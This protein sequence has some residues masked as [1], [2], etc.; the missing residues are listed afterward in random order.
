MVAIS[1]LGASV[2]FPRDTI[3]SDSLSRLDVPLS[4]RRV[5]IR[6]S[7]TLVLPL[8]SPTRSHGTDTV[9]YDMMD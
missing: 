9:L 8:E 4:W 5:S 2:L 1:S 3:H 6:P 7:L